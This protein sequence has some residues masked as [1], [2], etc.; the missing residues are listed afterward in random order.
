[1][2]SFCFNVFRRRIEV[3]CEILRCDMCDPLLCEWLWVTKVRKENS[4]NI[5]QSCMYQKTHGWYVWYIC[6]A[7]PCWIKWIR[8]HGRCRRHS[9]PNV[10]S[11]GVCD[12]TFLC[13]TRT[14]RRHRILW[15]PSKRCSSMRNT[16][17]SFLSFRMAL[18]ASV[19]KKQNSQPGPLSSTY[20]AL[21]SRPMLW[22]H[23]QPLSV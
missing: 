8:P 11:Y 16:R 18:S 13:S 22:S 6:L 20:S 10:T 7:N 21:Q 12:S 1:M 17:A 2:F 3:F 4:L 5:L 15:E 9:K 14:T 23:L 19:Q